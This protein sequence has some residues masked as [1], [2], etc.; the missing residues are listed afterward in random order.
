M[1]NIFISYSSEDRDSARRLAQAL[2]QKGWSVWWDR[3]IAVGQ[4]YQRVI[5]TELDAADCVI[6]I[7][8]EKS[9]ASDWVVAEAAEGRERNLLVPVSIDNAKPPLIFRQIQTADLSQWDGRPASPVFRQL[10][11][12]IHP[13]IAGSKR[14]ETP[15]PQAPSPEPTAAP[16]PAPTGGK[17][18]KWYASAAALVIVIGL[19][20]AWPYAKSWLLSGQQRISHAQVIDFTADPPQ[21]EEGGSV[22]LSWRTE[23]AQKVTLSTE[24]NAAGDSIAPAGTK[25][26]H[27][28][29]TT[30][31]FLKAQGTDPDQKV[32]V[33]RLTVTVIPPAITPDPQIVV[34]EADRK[35]LMRGD[36]TALHW[37]TAHAARIELD[38]A[39]VNPSGD[40]KIRPDQTTIYRLMAF[41][42]SGKSSSNAVTITVEDLP[43]DEIAEIQK[44]LGT[45][46]YDPGTA[47]GQPGP[48]TRAAIEAFQNDTGL[49]V[50]GLPSRDLAERLRT[51]HRSFPVIESLTV[52]RQRIGPNDKTAI[53]WRTSGAERVELMPFGE[54]DLSGSKAVSPDKTTTY[55]LVATSSAGAKAN[56]SVTI[57]VGCPP[58]IDKFWA[59]SNSIKQGATTYLRW[60]TS[61][62]DGVAIDPLDKNLKPDGSRMVS[63]DKTTTY[64][65]IAWNS[66]K[67]SIRQKVTI[68]VDAATVS[69]GTI[70]LAGGGKYLDDKR[71]IYAILYG[72]PLDGIAT[73]LF[74]KVQTIFEFPLGKNRTD[75]AKYNYDVK[76]SKTL[77]AEAGLVNGLDA[78]L[79]YT[80]DLTKLAPAVQSYLK[81]IGIEVNSRAF[82]PAT[83][84]KAAESLIVKTGQPTLL[85]ESTK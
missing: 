69:G 70:I 59:D 72:V 15:A 42:E 80:E 63:P 7:W 83:A 31:F 22:T 30:V 24:E 54:V 13:L 39:A 10:V 2:E 3:K 79:V 20:A 33:A 38:G 75:A 78:Y 74:G 53:H 41:N 51:A 40:I 85:L 26:V 21:I 9:V 47:D 27:P 36:S 76:R 73:K 5:E 84:R 37:E 52:D 1:S 43:R 62:A 50:T 48:R 49:P 81:R 29:G 61:C 60:N 25:I 19:L 67:Q 11:N 65:L 46:G 71:V 34:F 4:T 32:A 18:F 23:N 45:L 8:S 77:M 55:E 68:A 44:L 35:T 14:G 64:I 28:Q 57:E 16:P 82:S 12:D 56:R 58:K 66:D 17:H 6:V